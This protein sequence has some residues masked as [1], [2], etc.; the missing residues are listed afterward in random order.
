MFFKKEG[1]PEIK[2]LVV[3]TV[4]KILPHAAFV[5]LD[6]YEH[7]EAMLHVSE[8]ASKWIK[9]IKDYVSEG[10]KIVCKVLEVKPNGHIDVSLKRVT[11]S[12]TKR[13]LNEVKIEQRT[14]KLIE[15]ISKKLKEEPKKSLE[16]IGGAIVDE[17]GSL[18]DFYSAVKKEGLDI[19]KEINIPKKWQDELYNQ[20][21]EQLKSQFVVI[22]KYVELK[23][24]EGDGVKRIKKVFKRIKEISEKENINL[25]V[26]YIS[27][28][29]YKIAVYAK[30]YK[31]GE[32]MTSKLLNKIKSTCEKQKVEFKLIE[33]N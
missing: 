32:A 12:E 1:K 20:I 24:K 25:K 6:E 4:K 5:T 19:I 33:G 13:K 23:S 8:V 11:N 15:A 10:K 21:S 14:E 2:E 29:K 16:N 28:P 3:C 17:F 27:S 31:D 18:S 7:L 9:N 26:S 30:N 22:F